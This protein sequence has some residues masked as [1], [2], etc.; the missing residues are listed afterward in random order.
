VA[1]ILVGTS[2]WT[3]K[4]LLA[5]GWYPPSAD[6][7]EKRLRYYATKFPIV[8]VDSS[9]YTPPNERN[10]VLWVSRTPK[11]FTFNVKAFSLLTQHPT[12]PDALY[13]DVRPETDKPTLYLKDVDPQTVDVVWSRFLAALAPLH[14]AGKLGAVLFQFP[15]WFGLNRANKRYVLEVQARCDPFPTCVEFRHASWLSEENR[16]ETLDF[17]ASHGVPLVCVDM[18]QGYRNSVPP[19]TAATADLAVVRFHGHSRTWTSRDIHERFGY[20]Y[21]EAE[22]RDWV[23]RLEHLASQT[24]TTHVIMNNCYRD[25]AQTNAEQLA[26]LLQT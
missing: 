19:V 23:P 8:E 7:A 17:L 10:S 1:C 3:D 9:Y 24:Q 12:R 18:P 16:K 11:R 26:A 14:D 13:R 22:L 25:Y 6:T 4:A 5:S 2:S 15:P 21:S 20:R